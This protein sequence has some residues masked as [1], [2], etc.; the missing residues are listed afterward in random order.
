MFR[1][2][3][4]HVDDNKANL[5]FFIYLTDVSEESG[6]FS[7]VP[8]TWTWKLKGSLWRGLLWELSKKRKYLYEY[9]TNHETCIMLE[10]KIVG[11]AGTCFIVDTTSLHRAQP[12]LIGSRKV[13]VI[14][15]NRVSIFH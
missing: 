2:G 7:C 11:P 15:F 12:V 6:P 10:K 1:G 14:S 3:E 5:K 9:M 8:S 4:F 13:A